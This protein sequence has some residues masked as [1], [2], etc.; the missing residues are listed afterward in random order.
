M[1]VNNKKEEAAVERL[2]GLDDDNYVAVQS[3]NTNQTEEN[4]FESPKK[5]KKLNARSSVGKGR[6]LRSTSVS[7]P[8]IKTRKTATNFK[9]ILEIEN[10]ESY[11]PYVPN[12]L[13]AAAAPSKYPPRHF[14]KASGY[15]AP[16]VDPVSK[17]RY[18]GLKEFELLRQKQNQ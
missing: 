6:Q 18:H 4:I 5:K 14:C 17:S 11:P 12:Y 15:L 2:E 7:A 13:T 16:Y 10:Y 9:Q 3:E 8:Q 1:E